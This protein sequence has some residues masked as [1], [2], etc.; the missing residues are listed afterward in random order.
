MEK[1][2]LIKENDLVK[3]RVVRDEV[4]LHNIS[5]CNRKVYDSHHYLIQVCLYI[6][7]FQIQLFF[8][9]IVS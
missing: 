7:L 2:N 3:V 5:M 6:L 4:I 1:N 9:L 8:A